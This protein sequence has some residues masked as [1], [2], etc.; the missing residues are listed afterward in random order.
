VIE[1]AYNTRNTFID[2][3]RCVHLHFAD[4]PPKQAHTTVFDPLQEHARDASEAHNR[5]NVYNA[6]ESAPGVADIKH[7]CLRKS[8]TAAARRGQP[9]QPKPDQK[10]SRING[11]ISRISGWISMDL[12]GYVFGYQEI[13]G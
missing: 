9:D 7:S 3:W 5:P 10:S 2:I 8:N 6:H 4:T 12:K 1:T 13:Y 11:R